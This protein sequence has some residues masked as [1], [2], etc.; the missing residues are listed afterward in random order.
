MATKEV[1]FRFVTFNGIWNL[2]GYLVPILMC[3]WLISES[4][5]DNDGELIFISFLFINNLVER[6]TY[7]VTCIDKL[8]EII[9]MDLIF[10]N[11][12]VE[13]ILLISYILINL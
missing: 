12:L 9:F 7:N 2:K 8:L 4:F 6:V 11:K 10:I 3:R 1:W 13:I 5:V